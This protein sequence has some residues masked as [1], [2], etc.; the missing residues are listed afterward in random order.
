MAELRG[1]LAS[2]H[3]ERHP[4]T[5]VQADEVTLLA[6]GF[7]KTRRATQPT[8]SP[9]VASPP[10]KEGNQDRAQRALRRE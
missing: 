1:E 2:A 4:D 5:Q 10:V 8:P 9:F 7:L 3:L 6:P